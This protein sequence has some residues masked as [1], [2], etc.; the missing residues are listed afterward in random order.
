MAVYPKK[1]NVKHLHSVALI[2]KISED[3]KMKDI[4]KWVKICHSVKK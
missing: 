1:N 4:E 2:K 3:K